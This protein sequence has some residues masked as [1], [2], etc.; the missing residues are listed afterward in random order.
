M[1]GNETE[2]RKADIPSIKWLN[3][4]LLNQHHLPALVQPLL[5][6]SL[7]GGPVAS[8]SQTLAKYVNPIVDPA[9]VKRS[10][11]LRLK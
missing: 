1:D 4:L 8:R 5:N 3:D 10:R 6:I 9:A 11:L 2:A 7:R